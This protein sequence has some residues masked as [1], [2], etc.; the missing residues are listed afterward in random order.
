MLIMKILI[1]QKKLLQLKIILPSTNRVN[2]A[3]HFG[4]TLA[5]AFVL[6]CR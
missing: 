4:S 3:Y 6:K 1:T 2:Q 5:P